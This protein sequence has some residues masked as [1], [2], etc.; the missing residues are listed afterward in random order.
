MRLHSSMITRTVIIICY[1]K[2]VLL[3][4]FF[5]Q[6]KFLGVAVVSGRLRSL[7][8]LSSAMSVRTVES[9]VKFKAPPGLLL[10]CAGTCWG[11]LGRVGAVLGRADGANGSFLH[12]T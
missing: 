4:Y 7:L 5:Q 9:S 2:S 6:H 12:R 8:V 3:S 1:S 10:G 11:V